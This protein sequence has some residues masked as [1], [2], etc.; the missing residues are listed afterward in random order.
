MTGGRLM[1]SLSDDMD[2]MLQQ[3]EARAAELREEIEQRQKE[4]DRI[5]QRL[6]SARESREMLTEWRQ[7]QEVSGKPPR[8][9]G[10]ANL[11]TKAG[12]PPVMSG[13]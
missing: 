10:K 11:A 13:T 2:R 6:I 1:D 8:A 12:E 3:Y 4:R 7:S 5:E 9:L